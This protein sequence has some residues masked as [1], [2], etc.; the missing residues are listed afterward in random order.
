M[1][2]AERP[3]CAQGPRWMPG[4]LSSRLSSAALL[5]ELAA[6]MTLLRRRPGRL[7]RGTGARWPVSER[8]RLSIERYGAECT[9]GRVSRAGRAAPAT[10]RSISGRTICSE[11]SH[12][13]PPT[14]PCIASPAELCMAFSASA[15]QPAAAPVKFVDTRAQKQ[16]K[17][18]RSTEGPKEDANSSRLQARGRGTHI[19]ALRVS[20]SAHSPALRSRRRLRQSPATCSCAGCGSGGRS[21]AKSTR[22]RASK[23]AVF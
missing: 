19:C 12:Q 13:T 9:R 8:A 22:R 17:L 2:R 16:P 5:P 15:S 10:R 3:S 21:V 4:E 23:P 11:H 1:R 6:T 18:S 7:R 20:L 14:L